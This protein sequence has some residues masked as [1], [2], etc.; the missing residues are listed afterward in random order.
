M[1]EWSLLEKVLVPGGKRINKG[2]NK[3]YG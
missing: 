1:G 2:Y 3:H